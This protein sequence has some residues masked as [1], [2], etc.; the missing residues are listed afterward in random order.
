MFANFVEICVE[1]QLSHGRTIG[2]VCPKNLIDQIKL[3]GW[4][5]TKTFGASQVI[6]MIARAVKRVSRSAPGHGRSRHPCRRCN[7]KER[8]PPIEMWSPVPSRLTFLQLDYSRLQRLDDRTSIIPTIVRV[9]TRVMV[10]VVVMSK[11]MIIVC[12]QHIDNGHR[13]LIMVMMW[14]SSMSQYRNVGEKNK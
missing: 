2:F 12:V 11:R 3:A 7:K 14:H 6:S 5:C 10:V 13:H 1:I 9:A 8:N 4:R